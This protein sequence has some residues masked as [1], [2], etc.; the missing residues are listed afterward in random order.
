MKKLFALI[1]ILLILLPAFLFR[2]QIQAASYDYLYYSPCDTPITYSIGEIDPEFNLTKNEVLRRSKIAESIWEKAY[3]KNLFEYDPQSTFTINVKYD[4]RQGLRTEANTLRNE[5]E[6]EQGDIDSRIARFNNASSR[7]KADVEQLNKDIAYW[8]AQGGAPEEEYRS[9][10]ERQDALR[11]EGERLKAE[12][13]ELNASTDSFNSMVGTLNQTVQ[14]FNKAL[15]NKPEGGLYTQHGDSKN[16]TVFFN[17]SV[18]E[19][20]YTVA[21][22]MGHALGMDHVADRNS[23]M[24]SQV[25]EVLIPSSYDLAALEKACEKVSVFSPIITKLQSLRFRF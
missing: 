15:E 22:E 1:L 17:N 16:I 13:Q 25:T 12:A 24:Y 3:K 23:I 21:H 5:L 20:V 19:F 18:N 7:F 6:S 9:L 14:T 4:E 11:T 10:Q 2:N 8:N